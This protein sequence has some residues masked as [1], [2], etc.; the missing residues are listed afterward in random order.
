VFVVAYVGRDAA[1]GL[2]IGPSLRPVAGLFVAAVLV[3]LVIALTGTGLKAV[4]GEGAPYEP[5]FGSPEQ[6][7]E[8][9]LTRFLFAFEAASVLLLIA[10][11]GAVVLA[12]RR[13]GIHEGEQ[14][15]SFT[16]FMRPIGTGTMHEAVQ[17]TTGT[18][19]HEPGRDES[20]P[21]KPERVGIGAA[22]DEG[23]RPQ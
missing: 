17:G 6:I 18:P 5:G 8:L 19:A 7:G 23:I 15:L 21:S 14:R 20:A 13:G 10:A 12:R 3:E 16:V 11:V 1:T 4:S 9:L 22:P 2:G